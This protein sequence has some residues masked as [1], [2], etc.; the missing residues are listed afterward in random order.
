[1]VYFNNAT[2][3]KMVQAVYAAGGVGLIRADEDTSGWDPASAAAP[4]EVVL[5]D[6]ATY[7]IVI[8]GMRSRSD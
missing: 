4:H 7:V 1:V 2:T 3:D 5:E 6:G 8:P